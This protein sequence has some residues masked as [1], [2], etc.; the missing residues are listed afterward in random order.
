MVREDLITSAV[1]FLQ[2]PSVA[3]APLEKRIAFLQSKNLTQEEVDISLARAAEDPSHPAPPPPQTSAVA[4]NAYRPPPAAPYASYPPQGYW[5]PPPPPEPPKRDWRDYFIM[6][7]VMGGVGYG[8]YFTAKR[9]V[10]PL[11][12]PPTQPQL[13][14]DKAS[15]DE[16]FKR[17]FDLLEQLNT[18][19]SALKA[20]EEARTS[21]LDDALGEVESVLLTLKESSRRQG[22]D[23]RRIEDDVRGLRD[24][25]PKA[26]ESQKEAT[27]TRLKELSTELK[28]LK[29]L[30]GNRM[31]APAAP[32]PQNATSGYYGAGQS[33][34]ASTP[35]VN[36][37][38][39]ASAPTPQSSSAPAQ[40]ES[41]NGINTA[42][43][44]TNG[45]ATAA[46]ASTP[47]TEKSLPSYGRG[48]AG[49]A[50]IPAW[51]MAAAKKTEDAKKDTSESGTATEASA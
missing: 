21:R 17:A 3:S 40:S 26:L 46:S 34:A 2:D 30:I 50:A 38:S 28:S 32:R 41:T 31:S 8:L 37:T 12:Q 42:E 14:Q 44:Q 27:D 43:S 9:Y 24:L 16:S 7:T 10:L 39:A 51:Q 11:I 45:N 4:N 19:T 36:G 1:S 15:V 29:T 6:A 20:S 18:D 35:G 48:P 47:S 33:S 22:D 25:I 49:R 23:N 5:Q 13:E